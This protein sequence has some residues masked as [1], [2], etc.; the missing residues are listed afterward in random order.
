MSPLP[1]EVPGSAARGVSPQSVQSKDVAMESQPFAG[2]LEPLDKSGQKILPATAGLHMKAPPKSVA[3]V[4]SGSTEPPGSSVGNKPRPSGMPNIKEPDGYFQCGFCGQLK[5]D[6]DK[7]WRG[8]VPICVFDV[9]SYSSLAAR[10]KS[11]KSLKPWWVAKSKEEQAQWYK[12]QQAHQGG[13]KRNFDAISHEEVSG[14]KSGTSKKSILMH[15]PLEVYIREQFAMGKDGTEA[16]LEFARIVEEQRE[17]CVFEN[18]Q[19]HVPS[20]SGIQSA[21]GRVDESGYKTLRKREKIEDVQEAKELASEG[22]K[23]VQACSS[24]ATRS[25]G[26]NTTIISFNFVYI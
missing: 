3:S 10:W 15:I 18:N 8:N 24:A 5:V 4:A 25:Y 12:E 22:D 7:R 14:S 26:H 1:L 6:K 2:S 20:Y 21:V 13:T 11:Q 17:Q 16:K 23:L 9:N 19:W